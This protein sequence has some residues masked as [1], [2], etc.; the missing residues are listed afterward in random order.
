MVAVQRL[1]NFPLA[2]VIADSADWLEQEA[3]KAVLPI[4][5]AGGCWCAAS[6]A[7]SSSS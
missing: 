2:V 6:W 7:S 4:V 5:V 3:W 1:A